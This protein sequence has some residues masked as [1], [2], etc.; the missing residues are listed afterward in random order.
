[1]LWA[2]QAI[3]SWTLKAEYYGIDNTDHI[4]TLYF[5]FEVIDDTQW[6]FLFRCYVSNVKTLNKMSGD[7]RILAM[8]LTWIII[9][10]FVVDLSQ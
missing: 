3:S 7:L 6:L 2:S 8:C 1:M 10:K 4:L 9:T 5:Q